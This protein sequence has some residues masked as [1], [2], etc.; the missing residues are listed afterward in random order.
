MAYLKVFLYYFIINMTAF[1]LI[2]PFMLKFLVGKE[3]NYFKFCFR[4]FLPVSFF[5][6]IIQVLK[7]AYKVESDFKL[8][9]KI[10]QQ[11]KII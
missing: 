8:L 4:T 2:M 6:S 9:E 7:L 10:L 3:E 5:I 11:L 1:T